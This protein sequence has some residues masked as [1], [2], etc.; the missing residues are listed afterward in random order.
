MKRLIGMTLCLVILTV[1]L[2]GSGFATIASADTVEAKEPITLTAFIMQSVSTDFG[3][4]SNWLTQI[5]KEDLNIEIEFL[6]TGDAVEQKMQAFMASGELP[7]IVGFKETKQAASAVEANLLL[8]LE[9][10]QEYMPNVF[11]DESLQNAVNYY[12]DNVSAGKNKLY[13]LPTAI[14]GGASTSS[15][16]WSTLLMWK[17]YSEIGRP[18]IN[19]LEDYLDVIEQMLEVYP[20]NSE[21]EKVYG[22]GLWSDW[23]SLNALEVATLSFFYGIDTEY[24]SPLMETHVTELWT[25]SLLDDNSFYKRALQFYFDANQRGI[26]DPDS[27]TQTFDTTRQ[28]YTAGRYL[29]SWFSWMTGDYNSRGTGNVTAEDP[30]GYVFVPAKDFEIYDAPI[31][32]IGRSWSYAISASTKHPERACEWINWFYG[33]YNNVIMRNGPQGVTWDMTDEG[34]PYLTDEGFYYIDNPNEELP[35]GSSLNKGG[36]LFNTKPISTHPDWPYGVVYSTWPLS[37]RDPTNLTVA[38]R[39]WFGYKDQVNYLTST[40]KLR[41]ASQAINMID[42]VPESLQMTMNQ[43]GDVVRTNSWKM[44][45]AKDKAEFDSLWN[46]MQLKAEGLGIEEVTNYYTT[47]FAEAV[48]RA[49]K[50][51]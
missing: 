48:E 9:D 29:F 34:E 36:E 46:D 17:L 6:P 26:L 47:A 25:R 28:K 49:S 35:G 43:I 14:N 21:G 19:T 12:R 32:T 31:Q 2:G 15:T 45:F 44:I 41:Q 13:V 18:D 23:D 30:N 38:W 37:E 51:E 11:E 4:V 42:A 16:N 10:Y 27:L 1:L 33:A 8:C 22:M 3:V 7:D 5:M 24:V 40:G 39:E 50:Y 20:T